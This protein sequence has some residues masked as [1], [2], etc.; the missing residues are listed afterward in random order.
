MSKKKSQTRATPTEE[1]A[2]AVLAPLPAAVAAATVFVAAGSVLVLEILSV[3]L[4]AP[5]V[6]L[7]LETTSTI[8]GAVLFGIAAGA[9]IG[10]RVADRTDPRRLVVALLIV[11]GLLTLLTV[12]IVRWLGPSARE[13]GTFDALWVTFAALVPAAGVLSA[14]SPTV[15]HWQLRDLQASGTIVGGLS[16]WATGGALVGTFGTGFVLVPH[17]SSTTA[18]LGVAILLVLAGIALWIYTL[19]LRVRGIGSAILSTAAL[20]VIGPA[21]HNPC[22]VET[23]YHC[24]RI[25]DSEET[26]SGRYLVLDSECCDSFVDLDNPRNLGSFR[27][28]RWVTEAVKELGQPKEPLD[29]VF[30]GGGGFTLPRWLAAERPGS[31]SNTLE[32]DGGLVEFDRK[33]L[34]LR[35]SP[36][37]RATVGDARLTMRHEPT[38]SADFVVGDAYSGLTIPFQ[39]TTVE[40]LREIRRVLKPNGLYA[41][42]LIDL[43]P[44]SLLRAEGAT[45]L[46]VFK[47]VRLVTPAGSDGRPA[48]DNMVLLASNGPLPPAP[49]KPAAGASV[50]EQAAVEELIA[51]AKPLTDDYAPVDQLQTR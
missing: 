3:R 7:T 25:E 15:A 30:V 43:R 27:Y 5:Y 37:L 1:E 8:I 39:L 6:G 14:I 16:A 9:G 51:G 42:N 20:G 19:G 22:E 11:G 36:T 35:T 47:H 12:P 40:W 45:L 33:H 2:P 49:A 26:P 13:G 4:L 46:R 44:L 34:G 32:L 17:L 31:R 21:L 18:L 28:T 24:V 48:G 38:G 50:Y 23:S 41:L 29:A 10:G